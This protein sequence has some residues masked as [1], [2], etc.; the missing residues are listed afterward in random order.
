MLRTLDRRIDKSRILASNYSLRVFGSANLTASIK[1]TPQLSLK[2]F[3]FCH[4]MLASVVEG[5]RPSGWALPRIYSCR[6]MYVDALN[7]FDGGYR[8]V[9]GA[10]ATAG[11]FVT[12]PQ[13][14]LTTLG[15]FADQVRIVSSTDLH[16]HW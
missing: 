8:T 13:P 12:F 4:K 14:Y 10:N 1:F 3:A 9:Q 16:A 7:H 15:G 6:V 11:I 2:T 5:E